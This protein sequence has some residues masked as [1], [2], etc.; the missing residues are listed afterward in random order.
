MLSFHP[1]LTTRLFYVLGNRFAMLN[2]IFILALLT[3]AVLSRVNESVDD[4]QWV[5]GD[6]RQICSKECEETC[7]EC[8]D[9][10]QCDPETEIVCDCEAQTHSEYQWITNCPCNEICVPKHC[11]CK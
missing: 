4:R 11:E 10:H 1:I 5:A 2:P 9:P 6:V 7:T 3:P 8:T